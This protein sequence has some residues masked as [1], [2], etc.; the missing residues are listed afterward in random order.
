MNSQ[1]IMWPVLVGIAFLTG[2]AWQFGTGQDTSPKPAQRWEHKST[3][4]PRDLTKLGENGWELVSTAGTGD[5]FTT[6]YF[7]RPK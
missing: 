7:K 2:S 1:K 4:D 6:L 3:R 5:G